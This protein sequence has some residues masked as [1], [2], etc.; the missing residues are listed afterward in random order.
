MTQNSCATLVQYVTCSIPQGTGIFPPMQYTTRFV[1]NSFILLLGYVRMT[2]ITQGS[3]WARDPSVFRHAVAMKTDPFMEVWMRFLEETPWQVTSMSHVWDSDPRILSKCQLTSW[4]SQRRRLCSLLG[5]GTGSHASVRPVSS[6]S[7][8]L[9]VLSSLLTF[10]GLLHD[11]PQLCC[12]NKGTIA[13]THPPPTAS[14][15]PEPVLLFQSWK[16]HPV[17]VAWTELQL[18]HH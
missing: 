5:D 15:R 6:S 17:I 11:M 8:F 10:M 9:H 14:D 7:K 1:P 2:A 3:Y 16:R 18:S 4:W 13:L 12:D